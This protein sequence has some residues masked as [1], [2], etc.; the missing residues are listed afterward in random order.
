MS[1]PTGTMKAIEA[2]AFSI[3]SLSLVERPV[4][5]PRRGE[6]LIRVNAVTLNY[7]DLAVLGG[8]Y[9]PSLPMPYVPCS[10]CCGTV[11]ALG[12]DVTLFKEGDRVVPC[13]IQ[14]W[15]D[16]KVTQQQRTKQTLGGPLP[17]VLRE[18]IAVP[19]DE[20]IP[21]PANLS[22]AEAATL[23]IAALTA[24]TC[25][26]QGGLKSGDRVL[27]EGTGGVALFALQL[28]K[29]AGAEV[30]ALTSTAEKADMLKKL[31]ADHVVNYR[32]TPE[33]G[34]AVKQ[35]TD[36][37]G[38]DIVVETTGSTLDQS[39]AAVAFGGFIGVIG[40]VGGAEVPLNVMQLIGPNV[41][42]EGVVVGSQA[43]LRDLARAMNLHGIKPVIDS[44]FPLE[45]AA[46]AFK[47]MKQAG[48]IGKIVVSL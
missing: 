44:T 14:G 46:D 37:H 17:G 36:G 33:W 27:V 8:T 42:M 48:H 29:A 9:M 12:E 1:K 26:E 43:G 2:S 23:P 7:R 11:V 39:F 13:Y 47:H 41:R 25:L 18:Y 45:K 19:A 4:P 35:A 22:D 38:A 32:E 31:G 21:A 40:F 16:G 28:A 30:V 15:R 20:V 24:W 3:D 34:A 10:D 5:I 6:V